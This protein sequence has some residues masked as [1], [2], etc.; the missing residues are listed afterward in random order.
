MLTV[1]KG[2]YNPGTT[3]NGSTTSSSQSFSVVGSA[4]AIIRVA[5]NQ[6]TYVLLSTAAATVTSS[7]GML[8]PAGG[9]EFF[10]S[11]P[12]QTIVSYLQVS[13]AGNICLTELA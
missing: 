1:K 8:I 13:T 4:T 11:V 10:V 7:N 5:V 2:A 6:D 9:V 3:Q 12:G